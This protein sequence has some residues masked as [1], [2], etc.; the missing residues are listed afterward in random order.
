MTMDANGEPDTEASKAAVA[1]L[2][3]YCGQAVTM[4][5]KEDGS[6]AQLVDVPD[7]FINHFRYKG[8]AK[9][10]EER[11]YSTVAWNGLLYNEL[12]K[13]YPLILAGTTEDTTGDD[14]P[15]SGQF[16]DGEEGDT[17]ERHAFVCD[18]YEA[19][20]D[21]FHVNWGWGGECN[22]YFFL[23]LLNLTLV[24]A[25]PVDIIAA[26]EDGPD[27]ESALPYLRDQSFHHLEAV[28]GLSPWQNYTIT[29]GDVRT[30]YFDGEKDSR[31]TTTLGQSAKSSSMNH[32]PTFVL[33]N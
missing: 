22:G 11:R 4:W 27:S 8:Q 17:S 5:H 16:S 28:I 12:L 29:N 1:Q 19:D 15:T 31:E 6:A 24:D 32:T 20:T 7:A 23:D 18:G 3:R 33:L 2:M 21:C 9:W 30:Y 25:S 13:G 26:T 14:D 10:V